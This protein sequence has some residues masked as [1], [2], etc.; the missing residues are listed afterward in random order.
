MND[1]AR[2]MQ[3]HLVLV[4]QAGA[5]PAVSDAATALLTQ[6]RPMGLA[7]TVAVD[8]AAAAA[9]RAA[10]TGSGDWGLAAIV[11]PENEGNSLPKTL[12]ACRAAGLDI[13]TVYSAA[14]GT[15]RRV[16]ADLPR[17]AVRTVIDGAPGNRRAALPVHIVRLSVDATA[18]ATSWWRRWTAVDV[19]QLQP[20]Q[21]RCATVAV[22]VAR[23]TTAGMTGRRQV[24][25][26]I[27]SLGQLQAAGRL[28]TVAVRAAAAA[29]N[30]GR[31][32]A[33]QQSILRAA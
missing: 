13:D 20:G 24:T 27:T 4:C 11:P 19:S 15:L 26:L 23:L 25:R 18:P 12:A 21:S 31:R 5:T 7:C 17:L 1:V 9:G 22:D 3:V 28:Q 16:Q 6:V 32:P 8:E 2:P 14:P 29:M 33:P 30:F 10:I